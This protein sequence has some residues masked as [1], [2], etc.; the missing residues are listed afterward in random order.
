MD[1][2]VQSPVSEWLRQEFGVD[3]VDAI[4][5]PGPNGILAAGTDRAAIESIRRRLGIS[6][7]RHG[8]R[9]V[10]IAGHHDCAGN[11]VDRE[12]QAGQTRRAMELVRSWSMG[13]GVVG[14]WVDEHWR[15][16]R[17]G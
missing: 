7:D 11:P 15:V 5:E 12:T 1:G 3:Y 13:V 2:R 17:L 4:T 16:H 8:S 9:V 6:V 10:A 14:L